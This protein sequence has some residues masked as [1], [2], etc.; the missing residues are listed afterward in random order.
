MIMVSRERELLDLGPER[1]RA[2]RCPS[3]IKFST[4]EM[5]E[6]QSHRRYIPVTAAGIGPGLGVGWFRGFLL[7]RLHL[8]MRRPH[9]LPVLSSA[10]T[11]PPPTRDSWICPA[12]PSYLVSRRAAPLQVTLPGGESFQS[13]PFDQDRHSNRNW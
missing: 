9:T 3:S 7:M 8:H 12:S 4:V 13:E 6:P 11:P 5:W 1:G 10:L 2:P